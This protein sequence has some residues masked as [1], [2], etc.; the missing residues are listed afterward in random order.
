MK[1]YS[2]LL[3]LI[4]S[5]GVLVG[6]GTSE[7]STTPTE[8]EPI[9]QE[10][11]IE[12]VVKTE[13]DRLKD[14]DY[15][16]F[17]NSEELKRLLTSSLSDEEYEK[18]FNENKYNIIEFDGAVDLVELIPDKNTRYTMILRSGDYDEDSVNGP[19]MYVKDVGISDVSVRDLFRNG[20]MEIG[21]NV[22]ISAKVMGFDIEK[23]YL[24]IKLISMKE[25]V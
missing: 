12:P 7:V 13:V 22:T 14:P 24:E 5:V 2:M 10:E 9:V 19:A 25:R 20:K 8:T 18:F 21:L 15:I 1:K 3:G 11:V 23:G 4:L 16:N 17:D 6:C